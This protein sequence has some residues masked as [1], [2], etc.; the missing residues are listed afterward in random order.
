MRI[1]GLCLIKNEADVIEECLRDAAR[2]CDHIY[3]WDNGS[4][5]GTWEIVQRL[6]QELPQVVPW[7]QKDTEFNDRMRQEI[8]AEFSS[9]A[10]ED[11]WWVRLDAD[12][13]Y[14]QDP[15]AFL[16]TVPPSY[17]VVWYA[18]LSFYFSGAAAT[19]YERNPHSFADS[20]PVRQRCRYYHNHWSEPRFVR[21]SLLARVPWAGDSGWPLA[22]WSAPTCPLRVICRHYA[23]RSPSQIERRIA[24]RAKA[25]LSGKVF[26]HEAIS[27]WAA[28][29]DPKAV[30]KH[31]WRDIA[32]C[33]DA[34]LFERGW[35][36]RIIPTESLVY[37]AHDG[38]FIINEHL[39]PR[40]PVPVRSIT[41]DT[42]A[43]AK[44]VV[45]AIGRRLLPA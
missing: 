8:F 32:Y 3:V 35:R 11:D 20:V 6:A 22:V 39:M 23:Y 17:D 44:R 1:H 15:R 43:L 21:H 25:A 5:D 9:R 29:V 12:E 36:S 40:I 4:D 37:D 19:E 28:V 38:H 2:W 13:F 30:H 26:G 10:G 42:R 41:Q 24:T 16:Y 18:S 45:R 14:V 7:R 31:K 27:N 33:T 34:E